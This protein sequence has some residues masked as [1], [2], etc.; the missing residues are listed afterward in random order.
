MIASTLG[1]ERSARNPTIGFASPL[2][3]AGSGEGF[4]R[5][6]RAL[7]KGGDGA[8]ASSPLPRADQVL[9][10]P[11]PAPQKLSELREQWRREEW[12]RSERGGDDDALQADRTA[13]MRRSASSGPSSTPRTSELGGS[14]GPHLATAAD[15]AQ[16]EERAR[17]AARVTHGKAGSAPDGSIAL[18][19]HPLPTKTLAEDGGPPGLG[20]KEPQPSSVDPKEGAPWES[21]VAD[22]GGA[23][24]GSAPSRTSNLDGM[25]R[26]QVK[27]EPDPGAALI[28]NK[29]DADPRS[30]HGRSEGAAS[31][32]PRPGRVAERPHLGEE[33]DPIRNGGVE[34][35][36]A[37]HAG[38]AAK[39]EASSPIR[40]E[41]ALAVE[42]APWLR[43]IQQRGEARVQEAVFVLHPAEL[44]RVRVQAVLRESR[45]KL[46][47]RAERPEA[48]RQLAERIASLTASLKRHGV[49]M[50]QMEIDADWGLPF[51]EEQ[52]KTAAG[53]DADEP[54]RSRRHGAR[55]DR[56]SERAGS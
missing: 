13:E 44:G 29:S 22:V 5:L 42:L 48:A 37:A 27:E 50:E 26:L 30:E 18:V 35:K 8:G 24:E 6:F 20:P 3:T 43:V 47:L 54:T 2:E 36:E 46:N 19:V 1:V 49:E 34:G 55:A 32:E 33:I 41:S 28:R 10:D 12:N 31:A 21:A 45:L 4:G 25:N 40:A 56:R 9:E 38:G 14:S 16:V 15:R 51:E 39:L 17:P 7:E 53:R 52:G 23:V 11:N